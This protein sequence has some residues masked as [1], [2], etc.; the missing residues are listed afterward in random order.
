[1]GTKL[2]LKSLRK[3]ELE[4][5]SAWAKKNDLDYFEVSSVSPFLRRRPYIIIGKND[6]D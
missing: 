4:E 2:D 1:V 3:T 5:A 6:R